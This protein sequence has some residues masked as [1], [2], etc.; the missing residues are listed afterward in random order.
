LIFTEFKKAPAEL[1]EFIAEK[2]KDENCDYRKVFGY[3]TYFINGN[4]FVGVHGDKLFLRLSDA[5][6]AKIK[7]NSGDVTAFEPVAGKAMKGYV[8]L[9]KSIYN[10]DKLF[11]EWLDKSVK[12]VSSLPPKQDKKKH[13]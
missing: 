13:P 3:P 5:D 9:P 7:K 2:M 1:L 8:V 10:D 4:M 11:G 6:I 12:Y